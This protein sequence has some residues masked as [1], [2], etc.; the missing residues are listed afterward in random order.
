[1]VINGDYWEFYGDEWW[2]SVKMRI[3]SGDIM[4]IGM[5]NGYLKSRNIRELV[6][7]KMVGIYGDFLGWPWEFFKWGYFTQE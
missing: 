7:N 3:L 6:G 2:F 4:G 1:M 5:K